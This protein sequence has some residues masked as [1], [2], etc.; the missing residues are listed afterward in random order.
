MLFQL[1]WSQQTSIRL[2]SVLCAGFMRDT[3]GWRIQFLPVGN[4]QPRGGGGRSTE[5]HP[6]LSN[7]TVPTVKLKGPIPWEYEGR[8]LAITSKSRKAPG[9]GF[10]PQTPPEEWLR[11]CR[12]KMLQE[13]REALATMDPLGLPTLR[14][15]KDRGKKAWSE[16]KDE[17]WANNPCAVRLV[18]FLPLRLL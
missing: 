5:T 9:G 2:R 4:S 8:R 7:P 11:L 3:K 12:K 14:M 18:C 17:A 1:D 10:S 15:G 13:K 16:R 6:Q